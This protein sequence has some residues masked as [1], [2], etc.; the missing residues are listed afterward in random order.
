MWEY[1]LVVSLA[2]SSENVNLTCKNQALNGT[3]IS[4]NSNVTS[5]MLQV[6]KSYQGAKNSLLI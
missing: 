2:I 4:R 5:R 1:I 3:V 6:R